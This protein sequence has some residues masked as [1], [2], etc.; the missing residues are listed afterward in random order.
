MKYIDIHTHPFLE[1]YPDPVEVVKQWN[2]E[3]MNLMFIVGTNEQNSR[4][5]I[6]LTKHFD[7]TYAVIGIHPSECK[8]FQDGEIINKLVNDKTVAIGEIGL[9]YH[10]EDNPSKEVQLASLKSQIEVARKHNLVVMLHIRDAL[11]DAFELITSEEYKDMTFVFHSYSGDADYTQKVLPYKNIFFSISGVVTF[12]NAKNLQEAVKLIPIDR[13][14][15]ETDTP[16]LAP[17]PMRGKENKSPYV[18]HTVKF[19]AGLK[20]VSEQT[21]VKQ[22]ENNVERVFKV[23]AS[24][25]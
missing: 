4:E 9:D 1:Y 8:G 2:N 23:N 20:N 11:E 3:D 18:K 6:E 10:Y 16:Y 13:I 21:L 19:I 14:F 15:S 22:I 17:T 12:K 7:N 5:V 24:K 25:S